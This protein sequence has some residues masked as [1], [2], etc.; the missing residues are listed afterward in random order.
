MSEPHFS[1]KLEAANGGGARVAV[2]GDVRA[3]FGEAR[4]LVEGTVNGHAYRSRLAVYGGVPYLGLAKAF[5]TETAIAIGDQLDVVLRRDDELHVVEIP[6][7]LQHALDSAPDVNDRFE[8][9]SFTHR[10]EYAQ[11]VRDAKRQETRDRRAAETIER[12][13]HPVIERPSHP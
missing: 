13:R 3:A 4:P 5:R 12:V 6:A 11:W 10:R 2:G 7:E 8:A 9:M 1:G